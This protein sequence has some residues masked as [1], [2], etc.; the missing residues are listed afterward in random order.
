MSK[1]CL[2]QEDTETINSMSDTLSHVVTVLERIKM[3]SKGDFLIK[4]LYEPGTKTTKPK[5]HYEVNSYGAKRKYQV[6]EIDSN[7]VPWIKEIGANGKPKGRIM[8][9]LLEELGDLVIDDRSM[10]DKVA[11]FQ[12]DPEFVDSMIL[13]PSAYDP[14]DIQNNLSRTWK[15]ITEHNKKHIKRFRNLSKAVDF[16]KSIKAGDQFWTSSK[17]YFTVIDIK[18]VSSRGTT[19][20]IKGPYVTKLIIRTV[21]G[22]N[23]TMYPD[24]VVGKVIYTAAPRS[25]KKEINPNR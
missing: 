5:P 24:D 17:K 3:F 16:F 19:S 11:Q 10:H 25:Y 6:V 1:S 7:G 23:K 21:D 4:A 9:T 2:S 12:I 15:E 14:T 8:C 20:L 13:G 22:K 18:T